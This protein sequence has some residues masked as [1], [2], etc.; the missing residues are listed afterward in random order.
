MNDIFDNVFLRPTSQLNT[1]TIISVD[2]HDES[3][4]YSNEIEVNLMSI[5]LIASVD[6]LK[7]RSKN[8]VIVN[9]GPDN[10][11]DILVQA[12]PNNVDWETI[13]STIS[14]LVNGT[15][16]SISIS[17]CRKYYRVIGNSMGTSNLKCYLNGFTL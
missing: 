3:Y 10:M 1:S 13:D 6:V 15:S 7:Y 8:I 16:K 14:G 11:D 5:V 4:V 17:D 2:L 9:N 12:S